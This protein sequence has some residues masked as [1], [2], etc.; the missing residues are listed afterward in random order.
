MTTQIEHHH[1]KISNQKRFNE[2]VD[3]RAARL[4]QTE[5]YD[6]GFIR[7]D[8][9]QHQ[10]PGTCIRQNS[11]KLLDIWAKIPR[12]QEHLVMWI[13]QL[14]SPHYE[15]PLSHCMLLNNKTKTL[16]DVSNGITKIVSVDEWRM[17]NNPLPMMG[18]LDY[19]LFM[20]SKQLDPNIPDLELMG[21]IINEIFK[22]L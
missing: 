4:G 6:T 9:K 5:I 8:P 2:M 19:K 17:G 15:K 10:G 18:K 14:I 21:A 12:L 16:I 3:Y 20:E 7:F 1:N 13:I 11:E 22:Q